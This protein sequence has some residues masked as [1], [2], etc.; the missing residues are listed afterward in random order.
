M[1]SR[2]AYQFTLKSRGTVHGQFLT[3]AIACAGFCAYME[4]SYK[5]QSH[6]AMQVYM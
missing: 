3:V 6:I 4:D 5:F 1:P 2:K